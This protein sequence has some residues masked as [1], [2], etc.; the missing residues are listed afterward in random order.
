MAKKAKKKVGKRK[1]DE[2]RYREFRIGYTYV[3]K[4]HEIAIV[5]AATKH[6]AMIKF[7]QSRCN[8][9][10]H[11]IREVPDVEKLQREL[12][13]LKAK[14]RECQKR[15]KPASRKKAKTSKKS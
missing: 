8:Y 7:F 2:Y 15:K 4:E 3:T 9:K 5:D 6:D 10:I 12:A 14:L 13:E 1:E 11:S